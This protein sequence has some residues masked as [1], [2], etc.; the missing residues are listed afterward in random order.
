MRVPATTIDEVLQRLDEIIDTA[1]AENSPAGYFAYI[2]RRTTRAVKEAIEAA[3]FADNVRMEVFDVAFANL[4][5]EAYEQFRCGDPCT[6]SWQLAFRAANEQKAL[7]QHVL[8][9]M[10]AHINLDLGLAAGLLMA[11]KNLDD[12]KEDF[13]RVNDILQEIIEELQERVSRVSPLFYLADRFGRQRDE[14]LLD[15]SMRA[16]RE[17]AWAV[18]HQVWSAGE[19]QAA[20]INRIDQNV[21]KFGGFLHRPKTRLG[22]WLWRALAAAE[23]KKVSANIHGLRW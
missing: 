6:L 16:A 10:N 18:A 17:Q 8:L 5:L 21:A 9:G 15:F 20:A 23:G 1:L 19:D 22:R 14:H 3:R 4:Y 7:L 13:R 2:Y 12:L 11:N